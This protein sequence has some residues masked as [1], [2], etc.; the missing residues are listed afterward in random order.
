MSFSGIYSSLTTPFDHRGL[1]YPAKIRHNVSRLNQTTL[2]GFLS[3]GE[4]GEG[5]L[6]TGDEKRRLWSEVAEAAADDKE[7]LAAVSSPGVAETFELAK[8]AAELGYKAVLAA[9]PL[10]RRT[11]GDAGKRRLLYF[12][13]AAD[14]SPLPLIVDAGDVGAAGAL[15]PEEIARLTEHA[16]IVTVVCRGDES[17]VRRCAQALR[18]GFPLIVGS[19]R[20]LPALLGEVASAALLS[21]TN[22]VPFHYL[23]LEE[24]LR[25]RETDAAEKLMG[26]A[27]VAIEVIDRLGVAGLKHAMDLYGY[28]GGPPRLPD[29]PIAETS[30][31][32]IETALYELAS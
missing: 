18:E 28:Y 29:E 1:L 11:C 8:A 3:G 14:R 17:T 32:E 24:A 15:T 9:A 19:E 6:L 5:D 20:L 7:L 30:K 16:N 2:R 23:S 26:C 4:T 21:M 31:S 10:D 22:A 12:R 27:A 25:T 13:A